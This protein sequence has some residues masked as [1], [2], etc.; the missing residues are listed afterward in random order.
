MGYA[1]LTIAGADGEVSEPEMNW[2]VTNLGKTAGIPKEVIDDIKAFDYRN[3]DLRSIILE[4]ATDIPL[5]YGRAIIYDAV[6]MS[7]ADGS[8][9]PEEQQAVHK[10]AGILN[11]NMDI[12]HA[13]EGLLEMEDSMNQTRIHLFEPKDNFECCPTD[14]N[15]LIELNPIVNEYYGFQSILRNSLIDYGKALL[16]IAGADGDVAKEEGEWISGYFATTLGVPDDIV[17]LWKYMI[18]SENFRKFKLEEEIGRIVGSINSARQLIYD[19]VRAARANGTYT[20]EEQNAVHTAGK[21][22]NV[23]ASIIQAIESLVDT[24]VSVM[25]VRKALFEANK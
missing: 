2:L 16:C 8:Y 14:D 11:V 13:L 17:D 22:L 12:V 7:R 3:G 20:P 6:R 19:A 23:D 15:P 18:S 10:A 24:E 25:N 1:L 9:R 4:I 5:N 21:M